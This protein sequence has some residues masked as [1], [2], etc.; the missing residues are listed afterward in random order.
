MSW[1]KLCPRTIQSGPITRAGKANPYLKSAL[2]EAAAAAAKTKT[3]LGER[4]RHLV[5][6]RI[7]R[8]ETLSRISR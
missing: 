4:Y 3:F 8:S 7:F 5:K 6:R 1:A 2:G